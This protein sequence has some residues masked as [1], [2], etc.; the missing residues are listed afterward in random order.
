MTAAVLPERFRHGLEL[1]I[2]EG[3]PP[4]SFLRRVLENDLY[5][6]VVAADMQSRR[7]LSELVLWIAQNAPP[8]SWGSPRAVIAWQEHMR[9]RLAERWGRMP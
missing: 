7:E 6:A 2:D 8:G 5:G 3:V 1:W 9:R 4:G